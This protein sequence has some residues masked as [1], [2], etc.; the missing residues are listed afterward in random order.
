MDRV[1]RPKQVER[2]APRAPN[3]A[4]IHAMI[5]SGHVSGL[6]NF[7]QLA[8]CKLRQNGL[9]P[10]C[11]LGEVIVSLKRRWCPGTDLNCQPID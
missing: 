3:Y 2:V 11:L 4:M 10:L 7:P 8:V 6:H 9:K 5:H 1:I